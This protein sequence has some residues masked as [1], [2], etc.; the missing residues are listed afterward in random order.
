[1]FV[2]FEENLRGWG[3]GERMERGMGR[4]VGGR[5]QTNRWGELKAVGMN[6]VGVPKTEMWLGFFVVVLWCLVG[7]R[8]KNSSFF[9]AT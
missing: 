5:G 8:G 7:R 2:C 3:G 4:V 6:G 1:V 9:W